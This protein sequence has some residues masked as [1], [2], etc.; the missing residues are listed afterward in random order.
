V[1]EIALKGISVHNSDREERKEMHM[2]S[3]QNGID[4]LVSGYGTRIYL[5]LHLVALILINQFFRSFTAPSPRAGLNLLMWS[6]LAACCLASLL[7]FSFLLKR[8]VTFGKRMI[9]FSAG[10]AVFYML[11]RASIVL[12][13]YTVHQRL[14][15]VTDDV[16]VLFSGSSGQQFEVWNWDAHVHFL[17]AA[18]PVFIVAAAISLGIHIGGR[19]ISVNKIARAHC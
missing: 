2:N 5:L 10:W 11:W 19:Y 17:L 18:L 6:G 12:A 16:F 13:S 4:I 1:E 9:A 8:G 14:I 15:R 3:R 7:T